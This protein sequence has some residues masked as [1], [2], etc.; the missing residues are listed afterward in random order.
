[1]SAAAHE[2]AR[3]GA[4]DTAPAPDGVLRWTSAAPLPLQ[5]GDAL[6]GFTLAYRIWGR[7]NA[8]RDNAVIVC[9]ALTGDVHADR[10]WAPLFG[11]GRALDPA[12]DFIVCAN[13]LGGCTG[14]TGPTSPAPDGR[15]W[16]AR[17]PAISVRDQVRA[18]VALADALG[19]R[20]IRAVVGGSMGGLQALEWALLDPARVRAV[21]SIAAAARHPAWCIAFSEAQRLAIQADPAYRGGDYPPEA[22]PVA[23]LAAARAIAMATYRSPESLQLRFD[24]H[25][26]RSVH[27]DASL[28]PDEFAVRGWLRHHGAR[29]VERFDA[30]SYLALVGAM[31]RHDL[32]EGR[33]GLAAA[34]RALTQPVLVVSI[35]TDALY[36]PAEQ[37]ALV[38]GLPRARLSVLPSAHG[39]DGFL[40][41][42][43][44]LE[45]LL[46]R[47]LE[48]VEDDA[49][50][51]PARGSGG[52]AS[53]AS[54]RAAV[55]R[56]GEAPRALFG[57]RRG[58]TRRRSGD[59]EPLKL[60]GAAAEGHA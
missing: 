39:H 20:G 60:R 44:R 38:E 15:P 22:P 18:Q 9:H 42:A 52:G 57:P 32:G 26:G 56:A 17:F 23:G 12:R 35:P 3:D 33:G 45:P 8:A 13:A 5:S 28:A 43:A 47:F 46:R 7:L 40:I 30:N 16:G 36:V 21:V 31:D 19:I 58:A 41:D 53:Q 24:R 1:M 2:P 50:R 14:S 54:S 55:E 29:L 6:P 25:P 10:W 49:G 51:A 27:G 11:E 59:A 37:Y 4:R 48:G 34:L